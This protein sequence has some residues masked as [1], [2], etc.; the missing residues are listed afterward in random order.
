VQ[1]PIDPPGPSLGFPGQ[2]LLQVNSTDI[3]KT[4]KFSVVQPSTVGAVEVG[5]FQVDDTEGNIGTLAP[6]SAGY[7]DA[8]KA[9][10][11]YKTLFSTLGDGDI[12]L[13]ELSRMLTLAPGK[14]YS[15]FVIQGA[16]AD[17]LLQGDLA[18]SLDA[19]SFGSPF[20]SQAGVQ[21]L[22]VSFLDTQGAYEL[23]WDLDRDAQFDD[24]KFKVELSDGAKPL[25]AGLQG[26]QASEL[27]DLRELTGSV[28]LELTIRSEA[29]NTNVLGFFRVDNAQGTVTDG[30]GNALNPGDAGYLKAAA[31]QWAGRQVVS[32][33]S[34]SSF[35][36][37]V[38]VDGGGI[39]VPFMITNGTLEQ[40]LDSDT[41]N[42]PTVFTPFLGSNSGGRDY[43]KLLGDNTFGFEDMVAGD[44]D[45]D[46]LVV[47]VNVAPVA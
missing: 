13:T 44:F 39:W 1:P 47:K 23:A 7:L 27:L 41:S 15:F 26:D 35:S 19:I 6:G 12:P 2:N 29:F 36:A 38:T 31:A 24:F 9:A 34:G 20:L 16:T 11:N 40:L 43:V 10:G 33:A 14:F 21:P 32:T 30:F 8:A 18:S 42:D 25:G 37:T 46:D 17:T 28:N 3:D 22:N 4:A 45:Y 5:Y